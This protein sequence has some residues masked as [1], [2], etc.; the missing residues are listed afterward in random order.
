MAGIEAS[1]FSYVFS[2]KGAKTAKI[3]EGKN[4]YYTFAPLAPLRE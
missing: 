2:R 1:R 4:P 3:N